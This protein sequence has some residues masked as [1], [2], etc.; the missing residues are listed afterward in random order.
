MRSAGDH[1]CESP[2]WG[3]SKHP[4]PVP[5][6]PHREPLAARGEPHAAPLLCPMARAHLGDLKESWAV[7]VWGKQWTGVGTECESTQPP[8]PSTVPASPAQP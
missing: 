1:H 2:K 8:A 4:L 5:G 7:G 6:N 3:A